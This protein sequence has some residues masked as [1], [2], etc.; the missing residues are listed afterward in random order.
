[1]C[2]RFSREKLVTVADL[3]MHPIQKYGSSQRFYLMVFRDEMMD[4]REELK[5][6]L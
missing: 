1:M 5:L 3:K 4:Y 2:D 6:V